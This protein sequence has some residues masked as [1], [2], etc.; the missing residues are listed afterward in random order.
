MKKQNHEVIGNV[1]KPDGSLDCEN[2]PKFKDKSC[3]V[4]TLKNNRPEGV[5]YP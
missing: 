5:A 1:R 4:S 2:C 3:P